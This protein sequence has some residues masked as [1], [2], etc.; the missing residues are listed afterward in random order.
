MEK[1]Y[2]QLTILDF[3]LLLP[4]PIERAISK[5]AIRSMY[6]TDIKMKQMGLKSDN[7]CY[8]KVGRAISMSYRKKIQKKISQQKKHEPIFS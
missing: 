1:Y 8:R 3:S 7:F 4:N 2:L 6:K 5:E